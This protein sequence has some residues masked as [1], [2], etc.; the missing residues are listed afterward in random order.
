MTTPGLRALILFFL[1]EAF[2]REPNPR[3][4]WAWLKDL[5]HRVNRWDWFKLFLVAGVMAIIGILIWR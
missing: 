2:A 1:R 5:A 3:P 4:L